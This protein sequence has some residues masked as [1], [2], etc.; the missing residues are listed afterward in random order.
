MTRTHAPRASVVLAVYNGERFLR[1][2]L[3]S[4][5][6][7]TFDDLELIV[8]ND[9]ST[10]SSREI[11]AEYDDP[12]IRLIDNPHNLGLTPSLNRGIAAAR[13]E[14][15]AR[16][17]ADDVATP[18]RLAR[19]VAFLDRNPDVAL[20]GSWYRN[21]DEHGRRLA[22]GQFP[23]QHT[24]LRWSMMFY[25]PFTH[26]AAT[27]RREAV[28][29]AVGE[30]DPAFAYAMD[31]EYW[32]RIAGR[33]GVANIGRV[34]TH[35]RLGPHSM[36]ANHPRVLAEIDAA[37]AASMRVVFGD[38]A[39]PWIAEAARLAALVDGWP[40]GSDARDIR[41][42]V[43]AV[44]RLHDAF[45]DHLALAGREREA[46]QRWVR[47]WTARRLLTAGRK[48][49]LAGRGGHGRLLLAEAARVHPRALLT[50]NAGRYFA[51]RMIAAASR[52]G[53]HAGQ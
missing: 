12:R 24:Q 32:A 6:R 38:A 15:I 43:D 36:S 46:Q 52:R 29:A 48:A 11:V 5:L 23:L 47:A 10:D 2:A 45:T 35:Y 27:W 41:A 44:L 28:A 13:G 20:V 40:V 31:W 53:A 19:Q 26:S 4:V 49:H 16:L 30:Y 33:L 18:D 7:Q 17:D 22:R 42:S 1:A 3:D 37:R 21:I 39:E 25:C 14:F 9:G 50:V 8:V 51:A 34:L